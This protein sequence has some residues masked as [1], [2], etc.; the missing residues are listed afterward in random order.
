MHMM[1]GLAGLVRSRQTVWL[2]DA[3]AQQLRDTIGLPVDDG[4]NNCPDVDFDRCNKIGCGS[5]Q[6]VPGSPEVCF[7]HAMLLPGTRQVLYWGYGDSRDDLSRIWDYSV[8]T[9][10]F[11]LPANQTLRRPQPGP[12]PAAREHLVGRARVHRRPRPHAAHP[13]AAS[14]TGSHSSSSP[15]RSRGRSPTRRLTPGSTR[16]R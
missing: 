9:G 2:T 1:Q 15:P 6:E 5:W 3:Q 16:R 13:R 7:M 11:S 10:A 12:Q 4:T 8:G 14:P